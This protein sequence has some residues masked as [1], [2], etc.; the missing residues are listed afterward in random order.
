M[1]VK[2]ALPAIGAVAVAILGTACCWGPPLAIALLGTSGSFF[3]ALHPYMPYIWAF[4]AVQ[5][6]VAFWLVY[7]PCSHSKCAAGS[8]PD[9]HASNLRMKKTILWVVAFAVVGLNV[10]QAQSHVCPPTVN[11]NGTPWTLKS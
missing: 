11:P 3:H 10:W 7:R 2:A 9:S 4:T 6:A 5:L 1:R 8:T